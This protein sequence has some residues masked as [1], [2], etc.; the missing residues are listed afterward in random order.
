MDQLQDW[1]ID[2]KNI[3]IKNAFVIQLFHLLI[4]YIFIIIE[5]YKLLN[6]LE[7]FNVIYTV[8]NMNL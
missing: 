2:C 7:F 6:L 4:N 5:S 1:N 8:Y 3:Y